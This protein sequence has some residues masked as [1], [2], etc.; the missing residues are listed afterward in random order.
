MASSSAA[1]SESTPKRSL[2]EGSIGGAL[3]RLSLPIIAANILATAY[4]LTDTWW[5][6]RLSDKAVA[7]V[8]LCFPI[9]FL[10]IATGGGLAIAGSVLIAQYKGRGEE[11]AMNHVTGQ[12][13]IMV[14]AVSVV[15][16]ALGYW[17]SEPIIRL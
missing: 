8:T 1:A 12:T 6:G 4:S 17:Y 3:V 5:V 14:L 7:A 15:L 13:L 2:T 10:M 11:R 16:T 9:H